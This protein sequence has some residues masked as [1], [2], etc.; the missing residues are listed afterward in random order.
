[1]SLAGKGFDSK[2][3]IA[4]PT[5]LLGLLLSPW[6]WDILFVGIQHS[7]GEGNGNPLQCSCLENPRD[8]GA[9]WA[10][11]YGVAWSRTQLKRLSNS[12]SNILQLTVV[13]QR[14]VVLE[15]L[16]K[17]SACPSILPSYTTNIKRWEYQTI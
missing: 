11:G 8:G 13:Q 6:M 12:S 4:P 10:A 1:M 2:C 17:M 15:F 7:P 5:I 3:D 16:Q 9:W 14:V